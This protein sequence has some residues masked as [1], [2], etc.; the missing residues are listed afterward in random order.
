MNTVLLSLMSAQC[1]LIDEEYATLCG[2]QTPSSDLAELADAGLVQP[3]GPSWGLTLKGH[4]VRD[5]Y[6]A[7]WGLPPEGPDW[8]DPEGLL[9]AHKL[10]LLLQRAVEGKYSI[11][12]GRFRP[13]FPLAFPNLQTL[14]WA[15]DPRWQ[16]VTGRCPRWNGAP[17]RPVASRRKELI[18]EGLLTPPFEIW[19]PDYLLVNFYDHNY[20]RQKEHP[21][22]D[23]LNLVNA[24]R[25]FFAFDPTPDQ[26]RLFCSKAAQAVAAQQHL[27][28]PGYFDTDDGDTE[29]LNFLVLVTETEK[30]RQ[31]LTENLAA[32]GERLIG[33]VRPLALGTLSF[34]GLRAVKKRSET[35]CDWWSE[36]LHLLL[37][38]DDVKK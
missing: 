31:A 38:F 36:G 19:Q 11:F 25:H 14:D 4:Q 37:S 9:K 35:I 12:E 24:D 8:P 15:D 7:E 16:A 33:P 26:A 3:F 5:A 20:Y 34:E 27:D 17:P 6:R 32:D 13:S 1:P 23:P 30:M 21:F 2:E 28:N 22:T 10:D 18:D 29:N